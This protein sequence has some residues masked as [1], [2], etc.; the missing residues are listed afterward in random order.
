MDVCRSP[1]SGT[2]VLEVDVE[3]AATQLAVQ[4]LAEGLGTGLT[5]RLDVL[6]PAVRHVV[7][8]VEMDTGG[9]VLPTKPT[10][11]QEVQPRTPH[12][13]RWVIVRKKAL[14]VDTPAN[15]I[16]P[17]VPE[18]VASQL[19]EGRRL[20]RRLTLQQVLEDARGF[21]LAVLGEPDAREQR[22]L[23]VIVRFVDQ[24]DQVTGGIDAGTDFGER[25]QEVI[26]VADHHVGLIRQRDR[27]QGER[28]RDESEESV[29]GLHVVLLEPTGSVKVV[30]LRTRWRPTATAVC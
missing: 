23:P 6:T 18:L 5:E 17:R 20:L 24:A 19:G 10:A 21:L 15:R 14:L 2:A 12:L 16:V 11:A 28:E 8:I 22:V 29:K 9:G 7:G 3:V 27:G 25:D 13:T 26:A 1:R 30:D 4:L